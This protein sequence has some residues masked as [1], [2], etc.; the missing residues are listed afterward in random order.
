MLKCFDYCRYKEK[1][2]KK[3]V[4]RKENHIFNMHSEK[5]AITSFYN[6]YCFHSAHIYCSLSV[7]KRIL[8]QF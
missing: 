2:K 4:A 6:L 1:G 7:R 8:K 5:D 3:K